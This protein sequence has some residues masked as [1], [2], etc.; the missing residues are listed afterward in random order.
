MSVNQEFIMKRSK[1]L[2]PASVLL[3]V[4]LA[5]SC[6]EVPQREIEMAQNAL[7]DATKAEAN[8]YAAPEYIA[9]SLRVAMAEVDRAKS[10][11]PLL[12][13][14]GEAIASCSQQL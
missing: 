12:R 11:F 2:G 1:A 5:I 8:R 6:A 10:Q 7:D 4:A 14:Y 9:D 3:A 13:S